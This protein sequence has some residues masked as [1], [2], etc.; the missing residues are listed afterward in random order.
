LK[1]FATAHGI[2][3]EIDNRQPQTPDGKALKAVSE[4]PRSGVASFCLAAEEQ[5]LGSK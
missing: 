1:E 2:S 4:T 5:I 3:R